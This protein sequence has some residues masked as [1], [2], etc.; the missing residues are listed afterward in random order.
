MV[1]DLPFLDP[2]S[3]T[4]SGS[5]IARAE[6][7]IY[8]Q[9]SAV[10]AI[11]P[12]TACIVSVIVRAFSIAVGNF[13]TRGNAQTVPPVCGAQRLH[14]PHWC[15]ERRTQCHRCDGW[16][17]NPHYGARPIDRNG[18]MS[19]N[20][21]AEVEKRTDQRAFQMDGATRCSLTLEES[22]WGAET[23]QDSNICITLGIF[24][25]SGHAQKTVLRTCES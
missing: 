25:L 16:V 6:K 23:E 21:F 17:V 10:L 4:R 13:F 5:T 14:Q 9:T 7:S 15:A 3:F 8:F 11:W 12:S 20:N 2:K 24:L 18:S 19:A 22:V 1:I